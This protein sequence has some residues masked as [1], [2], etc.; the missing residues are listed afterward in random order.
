MQAVRQDIEQALIDNGAEIVGI[1][2]DHPEE[3]E[4]MLA[5]QGITRDTRAE[6][7][8]VRPGAPTEGT[9][10]TFRYSAGQAEGAIN[11]WGV[12]GQGTNYT[13][14]VLITES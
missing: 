10:F 9:Y 14:I 5:E 2:G 12:R 1:G 4:R 13:V 8:P 3:L 7:R 11:V 6:E